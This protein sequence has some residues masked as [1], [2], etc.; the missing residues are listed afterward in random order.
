MICIYQVSTKG[1][2]EQESG[3]L[4]HRHS[5]DHS[6]PRSSSAALSKKGHHHLQHE[7]RGAPEQQHS[8]RKHGEDADSED[9]QQNNSRRGRSKL[10]RWASQKEKDDSTNVQSPTP[11]SKGRESGRN[12]DKFLASRQPDEVGKKGGDSDTL[13]SSVG[14]ENASDMEPKDVDLVAESDDQHIDADR[15]GDDRHMDTFEKLKKR[16]ERF[17]LPM[18]SEKDVTTNKKMESNEILL[19][20]NETAVAEPEVKQ[21]RPARKRRWNYKD[22]E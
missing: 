2:S 22:L 10:E 3:T 7:Q 20:H 14:P 13:I 5:R 16:S 15:T 18:P 9:E 8:S 4:G 12:N 11:S 19:P 6:H 17:K 21:E 1:T